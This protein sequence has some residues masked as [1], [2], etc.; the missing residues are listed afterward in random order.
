MPAGYWQNLDE[1]SHIRHCWRE[2]GERTIS[3]M[4]Y[5]VLT[6]AVLAA[7]VVAIAAVYRAG[8]RGPRRYRAPVGGPLDHDVERQLEELR[9]L[10]GS[11]DLMGSRH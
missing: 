9:A 7:F 6:L 11:D 3:A 5:V 10:G 4:S 8:V 1:D 2:L